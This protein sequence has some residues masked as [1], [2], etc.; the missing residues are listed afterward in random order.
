MT[1]PQDPSTSDPA[2]A[3]DVERRPCPNESTGAPST[4]PPRRT[5]R[6]PAETGLSVRDLLTFLTSRAYEDTDAEAA[7]Q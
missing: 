1:G 2:D 7:P 5:L 4:R 3:D 6:H